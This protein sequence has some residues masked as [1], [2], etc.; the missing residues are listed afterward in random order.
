MHRVGSEDAG[1]RRAVDADIY[2]INILRCNT[3]QA[4]TQEQK[5]DNCYSLHDMLPSWLDAIANCI[6]MNFSL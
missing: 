2:F 3:L 5:M 1:G 6:M 4:T